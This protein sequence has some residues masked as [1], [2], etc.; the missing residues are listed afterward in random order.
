MCV[1][2]EK[3][4]LSP[5]RSQTKLLKK[6]FANLSSTLRGRS[7]RHEFHGVSPWPEAPC[8]A[9]EQGGSRRPGTRAAR[10]SV[11][12]RRRQCIW[13]PSSGSGPGLLLAANGLRAQLQAGTKKRTAR[14]HQGQSPPVALSAPCHPQAPRTASAASPTQAL[15]PQPARRPVLSPPAPLCSHCLRLSGQDGESC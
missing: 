2:R 10:C 6:V 11:L 9:I 1:F 7:E 14:G 12:A 13:K 5:S 3:V 15:P 8:V 4:P